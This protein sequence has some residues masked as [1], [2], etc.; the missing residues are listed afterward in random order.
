MIGLTLARELHKKG[1][2]R[3]RIVERGTCGMEASYAAAG[4]LAPHAETT[5]IDPFFRFC[6]E[7]NN[8]YPEFATALLE[9]TGVDIE[10]DR[11]G[12]L[13]LA[14]TDD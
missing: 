10:L 13:Y 5:R 7:S 9:E 8:L 3:I 11:E 14:L 1:A 2:G 4:M 12:T 6:S